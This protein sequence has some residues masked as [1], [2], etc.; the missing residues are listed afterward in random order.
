MVKRKSF[1]GEGFARFSFN[2]EKISRETREKG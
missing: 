1:G 2:G